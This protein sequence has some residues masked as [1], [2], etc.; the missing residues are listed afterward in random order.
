MLNYEIAI[1][2]EVLI[3]KRY[4]FRSLDNTKNISLD[5]SSDC[6]KSPCF[7]NSRSFLIY[8]AGYNN[9]VNGPATTTVIN[10][11]FNFNEF[12]NILVLDWENEASDG[13]LG[14][15]L[16]YGLHAVPNVNIVSNNLF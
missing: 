10:A 12:L 3:Y 5:S 9:K 15:D 1:T 6:L 16:G 7:N 4:Y 14:I 11:F 8:V 13:G 2:V